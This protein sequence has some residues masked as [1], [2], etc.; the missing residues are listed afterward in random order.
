MTI[1]GT[2]DRPEFNWGDTVK[3]LVLQGGKAFADKQLAKA[4]E[5]V[6]KEADKL[7]EKVDEE[8]AKLEAEASQ[9][10]KDAVKDS[11][12]ADEIEKGLKDLLP[13]SKKGDSSASKD[14][15]TKD[16]TAEGDTVKKGLDLLNN[17]LFGGDKKEK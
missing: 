7:R 10:L 9:K 14:G 15:E 2:L 8:R 13:G 16:D 5:L 4:R 12:V 11:G 17:G 1:G 6:D 3:N